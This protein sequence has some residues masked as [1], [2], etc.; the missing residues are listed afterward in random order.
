MTGGAKEYCST[1]WV[2]AHTIIEIVGQQMLSER[3]ECKE[4]DRVLLFMTH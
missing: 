1:G 3:H 2:L 4:E